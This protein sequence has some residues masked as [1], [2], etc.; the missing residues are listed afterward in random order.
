MKQVSLAL[1]CAAFGAMATAQD[2][3]SYL[4]P[5]I[6][7]NGAGT[8]G[9][10]SGE[11]VDLR[12]YIDASG[13]YDNGLEPLSVNSNGKLIQVGA[14]EGIEASIGAYGSH[15]WR[16]ALLGLDYRGD[17]R[18]YTSNSYYDG[19]DHN[20]T[21]GYTYQ[22]SRRLYFDWQG[23]GG[24]YSFPLGGVANIPAPLP[25]TANQPALLLFDNRTDYLQGQGSMTYLLSARAS[26]SLGGG[27]FYV[28]RQSTELIGMDGYNGTARFQYRVSR[29]TSLGAEY[30][31][32]HYQYPNLFGNS[33]INDVSAFFATQIGR[34]WT[35]S[36]QGGAFQVS[37]VGLQ[38]VALDPAVAAILG[39]TSITQTFAAN[40]WLPSG[41]ARLSRK[42]KS[43]E[44]SFDYSRSVFPGNGVYLTSRVQ[45][46]HGTLS[47]T[48]T[49]NL[50]F[51]IGGGYYSLSSLGQNLQP[52]KT[53]TGSTGFTYNLTRAL[54]A[55]G[56]YDLRQQE[57][58]IAG[59]RATSYRISLGLAFSP[60][61]LPLSLW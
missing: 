6:L 36:I 1:A 37:T 15:S 59:F 46:A 4:G 27:G 34:L 13:I 61:S 18:H 35:I 17:F 56:R 48:G 12:Y 20:L 3:G 22:K 50:S 58:T 8:I 51:D 33:D 21:L 30:N 55:V 28:H 47:Y 2:L 25:Y 24:T 7:T 40:D 11:Q 43:A 41:S 26:V 49:R 44:L 57:I 39:V 54:H 14:M 45:S 53:Y 29:V 9:N 42:F 31:R 19:T 52:Y 16:T 38:S 32:M 23:A 5:G 10:R 60:G